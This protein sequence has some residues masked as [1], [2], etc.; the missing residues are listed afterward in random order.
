[1]YCV[2][3]DAL[4]TMPNL[5][6]SLSPPALVSGLSSSEAILVVFGARVTSARGTLSRWVPPILNNSERVACDCLY[7]VYHGSL[8]LATHVTRQSTGGSSPGRTWGL[9]K[10]QAA[11]QTPRHSLPIQKAGRGGSFQGPLLRGLAPNQLSNRHHLHACASRRAQ[12]SIHLS[13][14][15]LAHRH[16]PAC[17]SHRCGAASF[18]A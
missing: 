7:F 4:P 18:P 13:N 17:G 11:S 12:L 9:A 2:V 3:V 10:G 5:L 15:A 8:G 6:G 14:V 1:M 16:P